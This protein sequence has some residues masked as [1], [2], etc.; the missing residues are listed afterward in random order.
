VLALPRS[1][2]KRREF[3]A[4]AGG[5]ASARVVKDNRGR[6]AAKLIRDGRGQVQDVTYWLSGGH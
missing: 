1:N 6:R 5:L 4:A 2:A 3:A